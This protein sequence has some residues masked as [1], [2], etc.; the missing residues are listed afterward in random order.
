VFSKRT[1]TLARLSL[2]GKTVLADAPGVVHG[3][4][5]QVA[6]AFTDADN[7][8]RKPFLEKG[9]SQLSYHVRSLRAE[10]DRVVASVRVT[11]AKGGGFEHAATWTFGADG[12][13]AMANVVEPFGDVP[14]LPRVGT[15]QM[16][17]PALEK[18]EWYGRGPWENYVDRNTGCD[19]GRWKSTV[20][21]QYVDYIRPQDCGGKTD[22]RWAE[23]TDPADGRGVRVTCDAPFFLQALHYTV[24]DLDQARHRPGEP[25]RRRALA[26]RREVCLSVDCRQT[27]LGCNN[28]GPIPLPQYR[29]DVGKTAWTVRFAPRVP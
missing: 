28:C 2:G 12:S 24:E 8:M 19:V 29:F 10:K 1:G 5:L 27:G 23:L 21:E 25:R 14:A 20:A 11:G 4:R 15:F 22:V 7:W 16:L 18:L 9:L 6:R 26:P 3:P 17:D 13:L